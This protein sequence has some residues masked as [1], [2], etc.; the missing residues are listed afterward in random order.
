MSCRKKVLDAL[1][2][3]GVKHV[4]G[5]QL[6][7]VEVCL[8]AIRWPPRSRSESP[9]RLVKILGLASQVH[10]KRRFLWKWILKWNVKWNLGEPGEPMLCSCFGAMEL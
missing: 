3:C 10:L 1:G 5:T 7:I 9:H 4:M 8:E 2:P 6:Q